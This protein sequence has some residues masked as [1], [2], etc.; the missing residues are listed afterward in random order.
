MAKSFSD[1]AVDKINDV[2]QNGSNHVGSQLKKSDP[3]K[4]KNNESSDC[5]TMAI[6]VL[7]YA[8]EKTG[9]PAAA[10]KVGNLG[11]K[12]TELAK[13]LIGAHLW[14]AVYYNPD[15]NHPMDGKSEHIAS[16]YNQ[17]KKSC[18][19]SVGRV[20]VTHKVINY[21]PGSVKVTPYLDL[22]KKTDLDY[23]T[24]SKVP[25]GLGMSRGGT[26]VW[27]Y[28]KGKVYESH[29]EREFTNGL[30][31]A[32]PLNTFPWLSGIVVVPPDS[33]HMLNISKVKCN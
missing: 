20:P 5:I 27:L 13:F 10:L 18:E 26:H 3:L 6:W 25:F 28:S 2:V 30:Y 33:H 21:R 8:F 12:G 31:T 7:K 1:H 24:F 4:Y 22:T 11:S 32:M 29:W 17:V 16:Y 14:K 23:Q 9:N 15:V 19:Y